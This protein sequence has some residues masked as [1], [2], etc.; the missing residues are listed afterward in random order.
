MLPPASSYDELIARF[1]WQIPRRFNMA[2][3]VERHV[4]SGRT[5]LIYDDGSEPVRNI[6]FEQLSADSNRLANAF[7]ELGVGRG[8]RVTIFLPNRPEVVLS[9]LAAWKLG[10]ISQPLWDVIS[11]AGDAG[12]LITAAAGNHQ[13]DADVLPEYPAAYDLPSILSVAALAPTGG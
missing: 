8:D 10:A 9:H 12:L 4:G 6:S 5:A 11:S 7:T 1:Q 2:E 13:Q 3:S